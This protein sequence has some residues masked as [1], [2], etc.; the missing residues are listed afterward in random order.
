[1]TP[2]AILLVS[3]LVSSAAFA[4]PATGPLPVFPTV[5]PVAL[6]HTPPAGDTLRV[7]VLFD[8]T[9][10]DRRLGA[11]WGFAALIERQG[12]AL[13]MDA[14]SDPRVFLRN[15]DSLGIDPRR[16][17][18]IAVSHADGDHT[19]GFQGLVAR[20]VRVPLYALSA[21]PPAF[22]E[23]LGGAFPIVDVADRQELTPGVF[24]TGAMVDPGVGIPEQAL[25]VPTDSGLVIITGCAHPGV[26]A[27]VRRAVARF[28]APV[29]L[30][31]GGF[32]LVNTGGPEVA[33][34]VAEFRRL[35]VRKVGATHC[36]G[37]E[38]I[39]AF[40]DAYGADFMSVGAGRVFLVGG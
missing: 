32:H 22:R 29:Y 8:N 10:A 26:V 38:A 39:A 18:A 17:E 24:T 2:L 14:G 16:I 36:T 1:M 33:E 34:I 21:F 31:V 5:P 19:S 15:L 7:T 9:V 6:T 23:G 37:D 13:L 3:A 30:V 4:T 12:H 28:G 20:G 11:G 35:G 40:A 25:V 27:I